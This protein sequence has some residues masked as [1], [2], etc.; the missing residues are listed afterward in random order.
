MAR[1]QGTRESSVTRRQLQPGPYQI[2]SA[3]FPMY[4]SRNTRARPLCFDRDRPYIVFEVSTIFFDFFIII[5]L[6]RR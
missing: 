4:P 2:R 5:S 6:H 3:M 1:A